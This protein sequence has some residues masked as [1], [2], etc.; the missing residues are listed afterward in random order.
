MNLKLQDSVIVKKGIK[1]PDLE[2]EIGGWQGRIIE[3]DTNSDANNTLITIEWDS[4]TLKKIPSNYIEDSEIEGLDWENMVL[5]ESELEKTEP[6][7]NITD[8]EETQSLLSTKYYWSSFGNEGKRISKILNNANPN[9]EIECY[10]K[11]KEH[12]K[13]KINFPISAIVSD[14]ENSFIKNGDKVLIKSLE[15]IFE[16]YGIIASIIFNGTKYEF[17][18][19]DLEVIDEKKEVFQLIDD[20][21]TWFA[22]K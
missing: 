16:M 17:P 2:F 10:E 19:C 5:Y 6:R 4:I 18:L 11:W 7:D 13:K 14:S 22:N 20:Y 9:D 8:V 3:I 15:D 1:E 21:R 12:L